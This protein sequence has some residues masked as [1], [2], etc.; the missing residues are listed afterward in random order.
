MIDWTN[1]R[2]VFIGD[3]LIFSK[4]ECDMSEFRDKATREINS[5]LARLECE[6]GSVV[7][8]VSLMDVDV[9]TIEDTGQRISRSVEIVLR[10]LPGT[11]WAPR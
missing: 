2:R 1:A 10:R 7:E 5:I 8:S 9:T 6:T 11:C 3:T 4:E